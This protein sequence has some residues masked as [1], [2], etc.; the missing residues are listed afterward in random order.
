MYSAAA[1]SEPLVHLKGVQGLPWKA[2]ALVEDCYLNVSLRALAFSTSSALAAGVQ[3]QAYMR[4]CC[5][6]C[7][8]RLLKQT[9]ILHALEIAE[10]RR[11]SA[12]HVLGRHSVSQPP[13]HVGGNC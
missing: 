5:L 1:P 6:R 9:C 4:P 13:A 2:A 8:C 7:N 12:S 10:H 3:C 11:M